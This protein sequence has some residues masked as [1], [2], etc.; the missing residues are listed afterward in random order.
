M[1]EPAVF[2]PPNPAQKGIGTVKNSTVKPY[3]N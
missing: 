2:P 3:G 1:K